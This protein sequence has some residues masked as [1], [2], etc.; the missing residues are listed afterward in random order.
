MTVLQ[1]FKSLRLYNFVFCIALGFFWTLPNG[2]SATF[3]G[4]GGNVGDIELQ[5]TKNQ[6]METLRYIKEAKSSG[7]IDKSY[8]ECNPAFERHQV[9]EV[10]QTLTPTQKRYCHSFVNNQSGEMI[11]ILEGDQINFVWT[12]E[13]ISV[14]E[15]SGLRF[16]DAVADPKNGKLTLNRD[17]FIK[18]SP[19]D[20]IFLVSHEIGHFLSVEGKGIEDEM[21]I[22]AFQESDGGRILLNSSA[23]SITIKSFECGS[24]KKYRGVLTRSQSIKTFWFG[25]ELSG[26]T[27]SSTTK[28]NFDIAGYQGASATFRYQFNHHWGVLTE[29]FRSSGEK[30]FSEIK[31]EENRTGAG[32]GISYRFFPSSNTLTFLG[33]SHFLFSLLAR[34]SKTQ[35]SYRDD[36]VSERLDADSLSQALNVKY[37]APFLWGTW[38]HFGLTFDNLS[39]THKKL[40]ITKSGFSSF[41]FGGSY[42]F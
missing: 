19:Q 10:L 23:A 5:A 6:L 2:N 18:L 32:V 30:T 41:D 3:V 9:C 25:A 1:D 21:A 36:F 16:V 28:S 26:L 12:D 24:L 8:C 34:S 42:A 29:V 37:Y 4:N 31:L 20:R 13:R 39:F 27:S 7:S 40:N 14:Q 15:K 35:F 11:R 33:Q 17:Y 22:G 38:F